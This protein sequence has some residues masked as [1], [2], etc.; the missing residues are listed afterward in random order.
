MLVGHRQ[1]VDERHVVEV[2]VKVHHVQRPQPSLVERPHHRERD[3]VISA[4]DHG[5][6]PRRQD[7]PSCGGDVRERIRGIGGQDVRV[8]YVRDA[9][10]AHLAF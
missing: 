10:L 1:P 9:V 8:T 7:R 2:G 5:Q 6:R 3:R 4:D